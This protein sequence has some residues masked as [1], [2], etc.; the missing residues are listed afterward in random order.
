MPTRKCQYSRVATY[1]LREGQP[2][3]PINER[4]DNSKF[5]YEKVIGIK[6]E[7]YF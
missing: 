7:K 5:Q 3:Y 2:S 4:T 6:G 1:E